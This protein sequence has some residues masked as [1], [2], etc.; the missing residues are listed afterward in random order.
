M[1]DISVQYSLLALSHLVTGS[2]RPY[3]C[4][5]KYLMICACYAVL[6]ANIQIFQ[7]SNIRFISVLA[8]RIF[9]GCVISEVEDFGIRLAKI[10]SCSHYGTN[11]LASANS[12]I[13]IYLK[14]Y[15]KAASLC[16]SRMRLRQNQGRRHRRPTTTSTCLDRLLSRKTERVNENNTKVVAW[17]WFLVEQA[18]CCE[19]TLLTRQKRGILSPNEQQRAKCHN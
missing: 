14:L 12:A 10:L 8:W 1:S 11:P 2:L 6:K 13:V 4:A 19:S 9:M 15:P 5:F 3:G 17:L 16:L 18:I 7:G